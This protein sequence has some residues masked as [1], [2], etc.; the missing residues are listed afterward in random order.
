MSFSKKANNMIQ[1]HGVNERNAHLLFVIAILRT[2]G[3][4]VKGDGLQVCL[5]LPKEG[6]DR[7]FS[8]LPSH[9]LHLCF[10]EVV[11]TKF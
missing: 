4:I 10:W 6:G 1:K 3:I 5:P 8:R 9:K 11:F 7:K 2:F